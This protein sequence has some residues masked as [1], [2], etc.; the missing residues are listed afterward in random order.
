MKQ[1]EK[2]KCWFFVNQHIFEKKFET[3]EQSASK[4]FLDFIADKDYGKGI[5]LFWFD[6]Y[7]EPTVNFGRHSDNVNT[8]SARLSTHI[9]K[10]IFDNADDDLKVK[11]LLNA[12]LLL[13][14]YLAV[15]VPLPK[16]YN[17]EKLH[18]DFLNYLA[19]HSLL[20]QQIETDKTIIKYF[21][22]TRFHFLR[23]QSAEVDKAKIHFDLNDIQDFINNH[24][25]GKTFGKSVTDF[26]FGFE[27]YDYNGSLVAFLKETENYKRYDT[28]YKNYLVVKHFD[29]S[30]IKNLDEQQQYQL[31]KSKIL[32]GIND[33][34]DLKRKPK[35]FDKEGFY[36]IM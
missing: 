17:A 19:K 27:L 24:I 16:G 30:Q 34:D 35:D 2:Y 15:R 26:D 6:I 8:E 7:V 21:E 29:Y 4:I 3:F 33:Y 12:A 32:E 10:Q 23:T 1:K 20:I 5:G 14:K 22:T 36:N 18:N 13:T 28:K 31:L 11:L 25:A 9:D